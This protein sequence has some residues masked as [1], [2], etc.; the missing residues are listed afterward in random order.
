MSKRAEF[1]EPLEAAVRRCLASGVPVAHSG[2]RK[3]ALG[4]Q[5][6][7][8]IPY[9]WEAFGAK[10]VARYGKRYPILLTGFG[11]CRKCDACKKARSQMWQI[12]AMDEFSRWPITLFGT[13]TL[14]PEEHYA[15]DGRIMTGTRGADGNFLRHPLNINELSPSE[16]F[17][18]RTSVAGDEVQKFLKRLR[19]GDYFHRPR[20]RYLLVA[21]A[22]DSESSS[23]LIRGRPHFHIMIHEMVAGSLVCGNPALAL[24]N[25]RDSEYRRVKYRAGNAWREGVFVDDESFL[26]RQWSFG[27]TKFQFAENAKAAAYLCKYLNKASDARI[28]ASQKYGLLDLDQHAN[29]SEQVNVVVNEEVSTTI[30]GLSVGVS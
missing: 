24:M 6:N 7:C 3:F 17:T 10:S 18:A 12:R 27:H 14:A 9:Q 21:E 20:I 8:E 4:W 16:L 23:D 11:R 2:E 5:P 19:K 28:R 13:I 29:D 15:L 25:G 26:R 30:N 22:H 1:R